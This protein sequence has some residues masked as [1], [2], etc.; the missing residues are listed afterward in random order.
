MT[1][2]YV[3]ATGYIQ[4]YVNY[5]KSKK[6]CFTFNVTTVRQED[7]CAGRATD[8]QQATDDMCLALYLLFFFFWLC[9]PPAWPSRPPGW[10][11][12]PSGWPPD[13]LVGLSDHPVG[14]LT[15]QLASHTL[16][17]PSWPF[18]WPPR[19]P[20]P[21]GRPLRPSG[22]PLERCSRHIRLKSPLCGTIGHQPL[23]N[24][25]PITLINNWKEL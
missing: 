5:N 17:P 16:W 20:A 2:W 3:W 11:P 18:I 21:F 9:L 10:P 15:I 1:I 13:P 8:G 7:N 22:W 6:L 23:R 19:L 25:C 12:R 4:N 14:L 24:R